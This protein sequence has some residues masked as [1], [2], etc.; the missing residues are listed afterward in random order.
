MN[1]PVTEL[2][3]TWPTRLAVVQTLRQARFDRREL[4]G[5]LGDLGTFLP[6]IVGMSAHNGLEFGPALFFAGLFSVITG[7]L[8]PIPMPVQPMKAIAA[9]AL[10]QGLSVP[11]ILAAGM[12][13][14]GVVL[15]AGVLGLVD[16]LDRAVPRSVVRGIQLTVGLGLMLKGIGLVLGT[17]QWLGPDSYLTAGIAAVA[18]LILFSSRTIPVALLLVAAGFTL[19]LWLH[20]EIVTEL[21]VTVNLPRWSLPSWADFVEAFP[22]AALPQI[23]LTLLNSVIAVCALSAD[24]FPGRAASPRKVAVSV[25]LMN[26]VGCCFGSMPLCHGAGGLAGHY[27]FGARTNGSILF[28]GAVKMLLALLLGGSLMAMCVAFPA[29]ILGILMAFAGMQLALVCRDQTRTGEAFVMLATAACGLALNNVAWAF[30]LGLALAWGLR[31]RLF[32]LDPSEK[33]A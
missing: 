12:A 33:S 1:Q 5:S 30:L 4:S 20:P 10:V 3:S 11:E 2:S 8:F 22:K 7:L 23:P 28:L 17:G 19:A 16:W 13:V 15:L 18:V 25:G 31:L 24:L 32:P 26:L 21:G 6:L 14:G 27:F 29:S 9:I